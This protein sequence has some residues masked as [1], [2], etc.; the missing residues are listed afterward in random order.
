MGLLVL[1]TALFETITD[2]IKEN[3]DKRC[4]I[5]EQKRY[6]DIDFNNIEYV[7]LDGTE[8]AYR[9]ET[10]E[11]FD[12]VKT[13]YLTELDGWQHYETETVE[14]EVE[15]G[16]NYYFTIKYKNG[17]TIYRKF[18]ESS[19]LTARLL[20]YSNK[21]DNNNYEEIIKEIDDV[22][23]EINLVIDGLGNTVQ[24]EN[25]V[26][27][28]SPQERF[29]VIDF[30][31]TGL[32]YNFRRQPMDEIISV[33]I[34]DQDE[35]VLLNT[36]CDTVKIKSWYEAQ[37][38]NGI[39]PRDVKGYPT[40]VDIMPKV[41]EILSSY[42]YVISYN[43]PFERFFLEGYA[44][45]YTP[46]D[47]LIQK[48]KWGPDPMEMFMNYMGKKKFFKLETAAEYFGC[49]YNAHNALEDA[50][51]ALYVYKALC[52]IE[53][54]NNGEADAM[55]HLQKIR[56]EGPYTDCK[57]YTFYTLNAYLKYNNNVKIVTNHFYVADENETMLQFGMEKFYLILSGMLWQ[58]EKG[59]V[60]PE[61]AYEASL[62]LEDF[63]T[64]EY[65]YL[66]PENEI[67]L[68]KQDAKIVYD[69][70]IK[71]NLN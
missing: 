29:A 53:H 60:D 31:T 7:T 41:I 3:H 4:A 71:N 5:K 42:D 32:N 23:D 11:E 2:T 64:G 15:D 61:L 63:N 25:T 6:E 20:E 59:E 19:P 54:R 37:C 52:C 43:V 35:K 44:K 58:M 1:I 65:D 40:F 8:Q 14:Y 51:A 38:V 24:V 47:F 67:D 69:Y 45:L 13:A 62:D 18:H 48:I 16:A 55:E 57:E 12:P 50:K 39:S 68:V 49:R 9:I 56:S 10:E 70:I 46:T 22:I 34:I 36:Y 28:E 27:E 26:A 17:Q 66:I 21:N 33:A 30:E